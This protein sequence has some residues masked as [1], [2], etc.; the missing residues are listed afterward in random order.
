V[1]WFVLIALLGAA[2]YGIWKL[3]RGQTIRHQV[4]IPTDRH[5]AFRVNMATPDSQG[6]YQGSEAIAGNRAESG[7][8]YLKMG[9]HRFW[10]GRGVHIVKCTR[11]QEAASYWF[12]DDDQWSAIDKA[13]SMAPIQCSTREGVGVKVALR[14]RYRIV[15]E[16]MALLSIQAPAV[17]RHL[18]LG[19]TITTVNDVIGT[20]S[21]YELGNLFATQG[22]GALRAQIQS[23]LEVKLSDRKLELTEVF[24]GPIAFP[25][26]VAQGFADIVKSGS[27]SLALG[28][29]AAGRAYANMTLQP[30]LSPEI[31]ALAQAEAPLHAAW[32]Q[33]SGPNVMDPGQSV[34][35]IN[36]PPPFP[37]PA[38][39]APPTPP[40]PETGSDGAES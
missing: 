4:L 15:D 40:A 23:V 38:Q 16:D 10:K 7:R 3:L 33:W 9:T 26:D 20:R 14:V 1:K 39:P 2:C 6:S 8:I 24:L 31:I 12:K 30:T 21:V 13:P 5:Y 11:G 29:A 34:R 28:E 37:P 25:K 19:D 36:Y 35:V 22:R 27:Y 32:T 18:V 17:H